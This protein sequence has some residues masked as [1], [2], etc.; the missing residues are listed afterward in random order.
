[1]RRINALLRVKFFSYFFNP[2]EFNKGKPIVLKTKITISLASALLLMI[3]HNVVANES[4]A[5]QY[6]CLACHGVANKIVGPAFKDVATKYK[7]DSGAVLAL[8][9]KVKNGGSGNW[10]PIP[11]PPNTAV[12]DANIDILV[13]WILAL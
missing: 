2:A 3:S 5:T 10:G 8:A 12:S 11:M 1:L 9:G 6:N 7:G 13:K 4:L